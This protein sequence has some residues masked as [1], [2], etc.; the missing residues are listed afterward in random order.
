MAEMIGEEPGVAAVELNVSCPNVSHGLDLGIDADA[1]RP[2]GPAGPRGLP[3]PDHRQAD[4]ERDRH[5]RDRR[6]RR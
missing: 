3:D 4:A 1:G 2:A 5:R 6:G